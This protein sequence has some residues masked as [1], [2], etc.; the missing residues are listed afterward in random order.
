MTAH[1]RGPELP[2]VFAVALLSYGTLI[3]GDAVTTAAGL[4]A[5]RLASGPGG[6]GLAAA[7]VQAEVRDRDP[8]E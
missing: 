5:A 8:D 1:C 3:D 4:N 6:F 7:R 2:V